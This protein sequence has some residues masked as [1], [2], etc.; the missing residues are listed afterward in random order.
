MTAYSTDVLHLTL[1][2]SVD[3]YTPVLERHGY[4]VDDLE[5][6]IGNVTKRKSA[7]L[8]D[9]M[10]KTIEELKNE[11]EDRRRH[12]NAWTAMLNKG[13]E[14]GRDTLTKVTRI[15]T[16]EVGEDGMKIVIDSLSEGKYEIFYQ[17]Y[18]EPRTRGERVYLELRNMADSVALINQWGLRTNDTLTAS[19]YFTLE[20]PIDSMSIVWRNRGN[21]TKS[22]NMFVDSVSVVYTPNDSIAIELMEKQQQY[23]PD[24]ARRPDPA[25]RYL[26]T[27]RAWRALLDEILAKEAAE[28][29]AAAEANQEGEAEA[30]QVD[31]EQEGTAEEEG[32]EVGTNQSE[33]AEDSGESETEDQSAAE[34][35]Q[36]A[37]GNL[38][39]EQDLVAEQEGAT[40]GELA[41]D[42]ELAAEGELAA[43]KN[44]A[45]EQ[46]ITTTEE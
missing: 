15:A 11:A 42:R 35:D 25:G 36:P 10:E 17:Y 37:E 44:L 46:S 40:E 27:D 8:S 6:T 5:Y 39:A 20:K 41:A 24:F 34:G 1:R 23:T 12:W 9:I 3:I 7:Q 16:S 22:L 28:Q 21:K 2:D 45:D 14:L 29:E 31:A 18:I 38:V 30:M 33:V 32:S 43:N 13:R 26:M 19:H 4:S